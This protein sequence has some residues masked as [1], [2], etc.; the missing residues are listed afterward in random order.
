[1]TRWIVPLTVVLVGGLAVFGFRDGSDTPATSAQS[2]E[3]P[4][5]VVRG[6]QWR[7]F[8]ASGAVRF[9]GRASNI[10]YFDDES[11]QLREFEVSLL[12]ARG[13]PWTASAPEAFAPPGSRNRMQLRGGVVGQGRWPDG[14]PL[15]FRTPEL[16]VDAASES[17]ETEARVEVDSDSRRARARGLKV[18][19]EKQR[20]ALLHEVEMRYAPR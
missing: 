11:A 16:W 2:E 19:G 9:E 5:Y 12:A 20:I 17:L 14:E 15:V 7:S 8:D 13:A 6:A 4:R 10:D 18:N 3:Q 1:M